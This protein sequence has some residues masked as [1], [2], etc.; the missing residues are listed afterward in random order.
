MGQETTGSLA[1][2]PGDES[3]RAGLKSR[4]HPASG[5]TGFLT[6]FCGICVLL[7]PLFS[8]LRRASCEESCAEFTNDAECA[9]NTR[10][11]LEK[12]SAICYNILNCTRGTTQNA[13][14]FAFCC[15]CTVWPRFLSAKAC[16]RR[17]SG[18]RTGI[19]SSPPF[20]PSAP[21]QTAVK[22]GKQTWIFCMIP[23]SKA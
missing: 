17:V 23:D 21:V 10:K 22:E 11:I 13:T 1:C 19:G 5:V 14:G 12:K 9:A 15:F 6:G 7:L 20:D 18:R 8:N 2:R 4:S 3:P 16:C